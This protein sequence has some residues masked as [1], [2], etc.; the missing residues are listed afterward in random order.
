M[1]IYDPL[2]GK[3]TFKPWCIDVEGQRV[4]DAKTVWFESDIDIENIKRHLAV[5]LP[6]D[7]LN[8]V[9]TDNSQV[10]SFQAEMYGGFGIGEN[11][12]G[13]R[14]G[15]HSNL[16]YKGIGVTPVKGDH[17][18]I[19]R[20]NGVYPLHEAIVECINHNLAEA[21]LPQGSVKVHGLFYIGNSKFYSSPDE[22]T[23]I[24]NG[25]TKL[26]ILVRDK[27]MRV[28]HFLRA[29]SYKSNKE[30]QHLLPTDIQ[31]VRSNNQLFKA[32]LSTSENFIDF[33][34]EFL[35]KNACQFASAYINRFSHGAL[36]PSNLSMDGKW[37]DLTHF[38]SVPSGYNYKSCLTAPSFLDEAQQV[39]QI[40]KEWLD[41][42]SKYNLLDLK[43]VPFEK[44]YF[45]QYNAYRNHFAS[46]LLGIHPDE[47]PKEC[48]VYLSSI[49]ISY[50]Q[51]AE[52]HVVP[53]IGEPQSE[54]AEGSVVEFVEML[55]GQREG[56][57]NKS[58]DVLRKGVS[59]ILKYHYS[60]VR[61]YYLN[62]ED[63]RSAIRVRA[64][65]RIYYAPFF[66]GGSI[67]ARSR[68]MAEAPIPDID[69]FI[70]NYSN[71][72]HWTYCELSNHGSPITLFETDMT[73]LTLHKG[74]YELSSQKLKFRNHNV[75]AVIDMIES[76][77]PKLFTINN[78]D[79]TRHAVRLIIAR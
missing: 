66:C 67:F 11:C 25:S 43:D 40:T 49:V 69:E 78:F 57:L 5:I 7:F 9:A 71:V 45:E 23:K 13:S 20:G 54:Q 77:E 36:T 37:L 48:E 21:I 12:G 59:M 65:K 39:M 44:Y 74:I 47:I 27:V 55:H 22:D 1:S 72:A 16:Q 51:A 32:T 53:F 29:G 64:L 35:S 10:V 2:K 17:D 58:N 76:C 73:S 31:R 70:R 52:K 42:Y 34:L 30:F 56:M 46:V 62:F 75:H 28:G 79:F 68:T 24:L 26:A 63:Y 18:S 19:Y 50:I 4:L 60:V 38:S 3:L 41:T 33:V 61:Q 6:N 8:N 15:N 14:T